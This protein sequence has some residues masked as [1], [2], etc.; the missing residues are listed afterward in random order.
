[1]CVDEHFVFLRLPPP[2]IGL[3]PLI[4]APHSHCAVRWSCC[5]RKPEARSNGDD[6][7][8]DLSGFAQTIPA[9]SIV[10]N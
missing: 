1:M 10:Q 3:C 2:F 6:H 4:G 9:T 8:A 5:W 7:T